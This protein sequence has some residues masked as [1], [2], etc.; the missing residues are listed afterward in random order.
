MLKKSLNNVGTT[1]IKY[2]YS[3]KEI[4]QILTHLQR[5]VMSEWLV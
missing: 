2:I 5:Y 1:L 4:T 3:V